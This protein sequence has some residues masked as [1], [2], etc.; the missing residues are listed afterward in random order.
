M[1]AHSTFT[2]DPPQAGVEY[3]DVAG[4]PGYRVGDDGSVWSCWKKV[5]AHRRLILSV[6]GSEWKRLRGTRDRRNRL[7]VQLCRDGRH[8][9]RFVHRIVLEAFVG[10][11]PPGMECC[12]FPDRDT[13]NNALANLRWDTRKA[14]CSDKV[15]HGTDGA[16]ERNPRARLTSAQVVEVRKLAAAGV[17]HAQLAQ[18]FGVAKSTIGYVIARGT[19]K[20]L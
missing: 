6:L 17:Q 8:I 3:R 1:S 20:N 9:R 16:G 5:Q 15:K 2:P 13:T 10:P 12:H 7:S 4:F 18:Q 14:N 11:C 19:W